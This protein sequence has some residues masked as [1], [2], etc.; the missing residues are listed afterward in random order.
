MHDEVANISNLVF[1]WPGDAVPVL[2]IDQLS[3]ERGRHL[4]IQ[5]A[6]GCGKT[7]LLNLLSGICQPDAGSVRVLNQDLNVLN[8][9]QRDRFRADHLGVIFQQFNLLPYL[10]IL[11]NVCLPCSFSKRRKSKAG[12]VKEAAEEM[13]K[14]L[15]IP[16][17]LFHRHVMDL[18]VGQQQRVAV[19]RALIGN[20]EIVIADEPTSALDSRSRDSFINLL[21]QRATEHE[22]TLIFVSHDEYLAPHFEHRIN[23]TDI[24]RVHHEVA[25]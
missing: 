21:F 11:E 4:F 13:L 15:Q 20:P 2:D 17:N 25:V 18:S 5:G 12:S 9:L 19:A 10:D 16:V 3:V 14:E 6:S 22:S 1:S 24:N 23:L 7:T 8:V